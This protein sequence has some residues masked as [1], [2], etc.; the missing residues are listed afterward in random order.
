MADTYYEL[1]SRVAGNPVE[2]LFVH[3]SVQISF[4]E[5]IIG[6][7]TARTFT[8]P[9]GRRAVLTPGV[10][11]KG[12]GDADLVVLQKEGG[13][14]ILRS[15]YIQDTLKSEKASRETWS[16]D[17][18]STRKKSGLREAQRGAILATLSHWATKQQPATVVMP[19]GTG[20]TETIL[21]IISL[22]QARGSL[23]IVPSDALRSQ[24]FERTLTWGRLQELGALPKTTELPSVGMLR[25]GIKKKENL[26]QF[27]NFSQIVITTMPLLASLTPEQL[28][29]L[30]ERI[31]L[32]AI[33]EAHHLPARTW[34]TVA[35]AF[36]NSRIV[37]FTATPFRN[38]GRHIS[39]DIIFEYPLAKCQQQGIFRPIRFHAVEEFYEPNSDNAIASEAI[40][41]LLAD[42]ERKLNHALMARVSSKR[43][44]EEVLEIYRRLAPELNPVMIH[45]GLSFAETESA[46][47]DL[48]SGHSEV[49]VCVDMLGEGFD[50][51]KLKI[52]AIHDAHKSLPITLQFVGR[53]TRSGDS[54][55]GDAAMVSNIANPKVADTISLLYAQDSDWNSLIQASYDSKISQVVDF[56]DFLHNFRSD[57]IEGF[58]LR[59][60]RPKFTS[61][62]FEIPEGE[63]I[64]LDALLSEFND[65]E[66]HRS[67]LNT[68]DN[69]GVVVTREDSSIEWGSVKSLI[70]TNYHCTCIYFDES[71]GLL[72]VFSTSGDLP[73]RVAS[74]VAPGK[75]TF[76]GKEMLRC[77]FGIKRLMLTNVGLKQ[78]LIG[79]VRYRSYIGPDVAHG[80]KER[81]R[82][83][84]TP[85]M[86]FGLGFENG[87]RTTVGCSMKGKI[88]AR[89]GGSIFDWT[90]W[91]SE[92]AKKLVDRSINLDDLI[93][94][95]LYPEIIKEL[96]S[97]L[98]PVAVDWSDFF[99][100]NLFERTTIEFKGAE[101]DSEDVEFGQVRRV[102]D[103]TL[104]FSTALGIDSIQYRLSL[105]GKDGGYKVELLSEGDCEFRFGKEMMPGRDYFTKYPPIFWFHETS[106]LVDGCFLI[107]AKLDEGG[108]E[109]GI[110]RIIT[111]D[112]ANVDITSESQGESKNVQSIQWSIINNLKGTGALFIFDDDGS[113]EIADV[114]VAYD[115]DDHVEIQLHHLKYSKS[116]EPGLRV[117]DVY[118]LCG[119]A[120][121]SVKWAS[122]IDKLIEHIRSRENRRRERGASSRFEQGGLA[123]LTKLKAL[124]RQKRVKWSAFLVQ[125]GLRES[126]LT[127]K[128][129]RASGI[130]RIL[131]A[132]AA[133]LSETYEMSTTVVV[134]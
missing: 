112:W 120:Q 30:A 21:A 25:K 27:L 122:S 126:E 46:K 108:G 16:F 113:G 90:K 134:A 61:F 125:P 12:Y 118:Q 59:N 14:R 33:D 103:R 68:R 133:Y 84:S 28:A 106:C 123:D 114:V 109:I 121:K 20:K 49:V 6:K 26:D 64:R 78:R 93:E 44:A 91:C 7:H 62:V 79:P 88:W 40:R 66:V 55:I 54:T 128:S 10:T 1:K 82:E 35:D 65:G 67:A 23:I 111:R 83:N 87:G 75:T 11:N 32:V 117:D 94:G 45:S 17:L 127:A 5:I 22:A 43:R 131:G 74:A 38:D 130:R 89:N 47:N 8:T 85:A 119:Q 102:D 73:D 97:D 132:T 50:F 18:N 31:E 116:D 76:G 99:F 3:P 81:V 71:S 52:A 41:I 98:I 77:L 86:L 107:S 29:G 80:M 60:V 4:S 69:V 72:F 13:D 95:M 100:S 101:I 42:K 129:P 9:T 115:H 92:M 70:N 96:P 124:T 48:F 2:K 56:Q 53:F 105:T 37:Q 19:T 110:D 24:I 57:G 34:S 39:G 63:S 104:E 15:L 36:S 58:S 51:P